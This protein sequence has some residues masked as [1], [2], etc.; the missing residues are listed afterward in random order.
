MNKNYFFQAAVLLNQSIQDL[1]QITDK[2]PFLADLSVSKTH[3]T[4]KPAFSSDLSVNF[5]PLC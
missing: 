2:V 3:F 4:D 1:T 5:G